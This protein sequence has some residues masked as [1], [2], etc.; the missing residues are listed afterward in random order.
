MYTLH[1]ILAP[2]KGYVPLVDAANSDVYT[3]CIEYDETKITKKK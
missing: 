3:V 2:S 1:G